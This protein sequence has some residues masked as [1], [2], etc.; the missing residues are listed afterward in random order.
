MHTWNT[1]ISQYV[2]LTPFLIHFTHTCTQVHIIDTSIP[3][4]LLAL[5]HTT[6]PSQL[7]ISHPYSYTHIFTFLTHSHFFYFPLLSTLILSSSQPT[8]SGQPKTTSQACRMSQVRRAQGRVG[9][10]TLSIRHGPGP[11][12]VLGGGVGDV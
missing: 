12:D 8:M 9:P 3:S 4:P 5:S 1:N 2:S 10:L 11:G 7:H 6:L